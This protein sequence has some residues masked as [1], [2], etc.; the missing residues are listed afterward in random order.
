MIL[1]F[2]GGGRCVRASIRPTVGVPNKLIMPPRLHSSL[3]PSQV[4]A[5]FRDILTIQRE[6]MDS[7]SLALAAG[8]PC[9][10]RNLR[11]GGRAW[12]L[13]KTVIAGLGIT[14]MGKNYDHSST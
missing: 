11:A 7:A 10:R 14:R 6:A 9:D 12:A 3:T 5:I 8:S 1:I 13:S 4:G 2:R